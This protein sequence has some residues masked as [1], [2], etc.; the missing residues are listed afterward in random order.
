M[1]AIGKIPETSLYL[2]VPF[3]T[4]K[5]PYC[6]FFVLPDKDSFKTL[7]L[8]SLKREWEILASKLEGKRVVSIY[9]GGGTPSLLGAEAIGKILSWLPIESD[10]EITMEANPENVSE[11]LMRGMKAV[12]VN[13]VSLGVQTL[14]NLLL[15]KLGRTH[16]AEGAMRAVETSFAAGIENISIDLMYDLPGQ[17]VEG[18]QKTLEQV[19]GLPISHLSLYNLTFEPHTQF[20]KQQKTLSLELPSPEE[21]L[22]MLNAAVETLP[23][24]GLERYEISA[25]AKPRFTSQHNI[26]YWTGRPFLGLGPSAFSYWNGTRYRN[27]ANLSQYAE[28]LQKGNSPVDFQETLSYP[29]NLNELLAIHLRLL[30]GVELPSLPKETLANLQEAA[31]RGWITLTPAHAQLTS[32]GLLFYD[33]LASLI[34]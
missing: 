8:E 26:G 19:E 5:C 9:F 7:Y 33:S 4:K 29:A 30:K 21:S 20:F 14:D 1:Q 10:Q 16:S 2:H 15:K 13:R 18:W 22:Q 25:F 31:R 28:A 11:E 3:C 27:V 23:K 17:T 24:F 32:T 12:G 6:H 34:I